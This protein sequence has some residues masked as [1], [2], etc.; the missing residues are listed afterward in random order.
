LEPSQQ[1]KVLAETIQDLTQVAQV[2][3]FY[4]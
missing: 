4:S 1:A 2:R 3:K